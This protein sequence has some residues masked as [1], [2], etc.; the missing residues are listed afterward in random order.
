MKTRVSCRMHP[1]VSHRN[2]PSTEE[3][4]LMELSSVKQHTDSS[5]RR[6]ERLNNKVNSTGGN[7]KQLLKDTKYKKKW[8]ISSANKFERLTNDVG[9]RTRNLTNTI[10]LIRRDEVHKDRRKDVIYGWFV[11]NGNRINCSK[12]IIQQCGLHKICSIHANGYFKCLSCDTTQTAR[13]HSN[14]LDRHSGGNDQIIHI[15]RHCIAKWFGA[16]V[17]KP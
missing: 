1:T 16:H 13:V 3:V 7:Y 9:G 11:V 14:Q 10:K 8:S 2:T 15:K 5:M 12:V 17:G 4:L 6:R